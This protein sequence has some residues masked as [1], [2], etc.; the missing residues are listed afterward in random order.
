MKLTENKIILLIRESV[1]RILFESEEELERLK[2]EFDLKVDA[3]SN[4]RSLEEFN[5]LKSEI[6]ELETQI[7][8]TSRTLFKEPPKESEFDVFTSDPIQP[9]VPYKSTEMVSSDQPEIVRDTPE[10]AIDITKGDPT[11]TRREFGKNLVGLA[12][13]LAVG[14]QLGHAYDFLATADP[15]LKIASD[16]FDQAMSSGMFARMYDQYLGSSDYK[17]NYNVS[18]FDSYENIQD[19]F[20]EYITEHASEYYGE[21]I[22]SKFEESGYQD[23]Y[24]FN[25]TKVMKQLDNLIEQK[26]REYYTEEKVNQVITGATKT[27]PLTSPMVEEAVEGYVD[28]MFDYNEAVDVIANYS[29]DEIDEWE[30]KQSLAMTIEYMEAKGINLSKSDGEYLLNAIRLKVDK[31]MS[32]LGGP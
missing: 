8:K 26:L 14:K 6:D 5:K 9:V 16:W 11:M 2:K 3:L 25:E 17:I 18:P 13:T 15:R 1:R 28:E 27:T 24:E 23:P 32:R 22:F 12:G 30:S 20:I 29:L 19:K 7:Q 10:G 31:I 4:A 21:E